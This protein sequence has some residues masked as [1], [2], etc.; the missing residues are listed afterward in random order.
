MYF[1]S[2]LPLIILYNQDNACTSKLIR[3]KVSALIIIQK[4]SLFE[5][6][7]FDSQ[8]LP[9][10]SDLC[11]LQSTLA[12]MRLNV[13]HQFCPCVCEKEADGSIVLV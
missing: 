7:V 4:Q 2:T 8:N 5:K 9:N 6:V 13:A 3:Y 1:Q 10:T 12:S 11:S